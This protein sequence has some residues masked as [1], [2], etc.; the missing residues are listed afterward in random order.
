MSTGFVARK[1]S[2][3]VWFLW[4]TQTS[5]VTLAAH[6]LGELGEGFGPGVPRNFSD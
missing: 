4:A 1:I 5:Q 6:S 2:C 3:A